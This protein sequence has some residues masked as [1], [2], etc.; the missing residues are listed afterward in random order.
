MISVL[1][2][3]LFSLPLCTLGPA[4]LLT[5]HTSNPCPSLDTGLALSCTQMQS[6]LGEP[7]RTTSEPL[8]CSRSPPEIFFKCQAIARPPGWALHCTAGAQLVRRVHWYKPGSL[9]EQKGHP[10]ASQLCSLLS[11]KKKSKWL[12]APGLWFSSVWCLAPGG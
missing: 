1:N 10:G 12:L 4:S 6:R 11:A 9:K 2:G 7:P 5:S 8:Q 3:L